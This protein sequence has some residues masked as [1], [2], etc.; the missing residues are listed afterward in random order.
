MTC[1]ATYLSSQAWR[2]LFALR[3]LSSVLFVLYGSRAVENLWWPKMQRKGKTKEKWHKIRERKWEYMNTHTCACVCVSVRA[4]PCACAVY[5][6]SANIWSSI[7]SFLM[8]TRETMKR[9]A[10]EPLGPLIPKTHNRSGKHNTIYILSICNIFHK[11]YYTIMLYLKE[12]GKVF[13]FYYEYEMSN[14]IYLYV[15]LL[16]YACIFQYFFRSY[17]LFVFLPVCRS[18]NLWG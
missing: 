3:S 10:K 13:F 9:Q 11:L 6:H 8:T 7:C 5:P 15:Y 2:S 16:L 12:F 4:R 17:S 1:K 14:I 18:V